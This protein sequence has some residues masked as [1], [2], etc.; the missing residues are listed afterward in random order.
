MLALF[1]LACEDD[2]GNDRNANFDDNPAPIEG[3]STIA[4]FP[5]T[6][7]RSDG[8]P[9]TINQPPTRIVSLSPAAT[10]IIYALGAQ[11][12][13]VAVD[14]QADYP[15][16]VATLSG[17]VDA[18]EP[19]LE[20]I[21]GFQPDL[22]IVATDI[23]GIVGRLDQLNIPVLFLDIDTGAKSVDDVMGQIRILGQVTGTTERAIEIITDMGE[24]V[25]AV[26]QTLAGQSR[27]SGFKVYHELDSTFFTI[28]NDTF[29]GDLYEILYTQNIA[30]DGGGQPYPQ[31]TQEAIISANPDV[32]ILADE[33]F[34]V[35][36][37]SVKARP[38]WDAIAAVQEDRIYGIDPDIISRPG[39][40]IIDAL[41]ILAAHIYPERFEAPA[42][43]TATQ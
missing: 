23:D 6:L 11:G 7:Q 18:F 20:A 17:R 5:L 21:A 3:V 33:E 34:G 43:E 32:I 29:I 4:S 19:N 2:D 16:E 15:P 13:L 12:S 41:E 1:A 28:S 10:E 22:V 38:G 26:R 35:T 40:R 9:I 24:R 31:M 30:G 27:A 36:I 42:A 39:P 25:Q 14:N 8:Q 37:D